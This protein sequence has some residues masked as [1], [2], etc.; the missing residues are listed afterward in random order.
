M[1]GMIG[2]G[3]NRNYYK[4]SMGHAT[5]YS[6]V[7]VPHP[8]NLTDLSRR[9]L[10]DFHS[11]YLATKETLI[12][13]MM[14]GQDPIQECRKLLHQDICFVVIRGLRSID[15]WDLIKVA[16]LSEHVKGSIFVITNEKTVATHC[17][18]RKEGVI[19]V[20]GLDPKATDSLFRKVPCLLSSISF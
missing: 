4:G 6:W 10:M 12:I 8:F 14:E 11:D 18:N 15:D 5:K 13:G 9:L 20:K 7:D 17:A 19:N 1:I 16:L 3:I 2:I